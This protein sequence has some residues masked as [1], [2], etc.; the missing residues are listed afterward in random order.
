MLDSKEESWVYTIRFVE[1]MPSHNPVW[2]HWARF[3]LPLLQDCVRLGLDR[4]FRAG[5][6][7]SDIIIS[8]SEK[9]GL[10]RYH[11]PPPRVT[12]RFDREK[13]QWFIAWSHH[14]LFSM[15]PERQMPVEAETAFEVLR[16]NLVDL[17]K[18]THPG[19]LLPEPLA[20]RGPDEQGITS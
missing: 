4:Y 16:S 3:L 11:P 13:A 12:I 17:W 7:I 8:A 2:T 15:L 10:E 18:E 6:S 9:H 14:L 5:Q 20:K 1:E 19:E